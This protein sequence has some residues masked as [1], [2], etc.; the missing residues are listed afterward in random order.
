MLEWSQQPSTATIAPVRLGVETHQCH[1]WV[2][3]G[4]RSCHAPGPECAW[5]LQLGVAAEHDTK[6]G[7]R[8]PSVESQSQPQLQPHKPDVPPVAAV[9]W[10][11]D[12]A[13]HVAQ[14]LFDAAPPRRLAA[15]PARK[16]ESLLIRAC[17]SLAG[18][19]TIPVLTTATWLAMTAASARNTF[20]SHA[21]A[22][23]AVRVTLCYSVSQEQPNRWQDA[24]TAHA[25]HWWVALSLHPPPVARH[26]REAARMSCWRPLTA[27]TCEA[28]LLPVEH[29]RLTSWYAIVVMFTRSELAPKTSPAPGAA[30][31]ES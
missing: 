19:A 10:P 18:N 21:T 2:A 28:W 24:W 15:Q 27:G 3:T 11:C 26:A 25:G 8:V 17:P 30:Q 31:Y 7:G 29:E 12:A 16:Q 5:Q 4:A 20:D 23:C 9:F 1:G 14:Q 22:P 6:A 13:E